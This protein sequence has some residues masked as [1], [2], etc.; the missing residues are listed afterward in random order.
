MGRTIA[1]RVLLRLQ[2]AE[3]EQSNHHLRDDY[4]IARI[5]VQLASNGNPIPHIE[6]TYAVLGVHP[7]KVW[8]KII[9]RR[10]ALLGK[11]YSAIY[12]AAG[13][14]WPQNSDELFPR[15]AS[16]S[17]SVFPPKKPVRSVTYAEEPQRLVVGGALEN[18]DRGSR[19]ARKETSSK[20]Q[21][22]GNLQFPAAVEHVD[23][24]LIMASTARIY[25]NPDASTSGKN[26][27]SFSRADIEKL[28]ENSDLPRHLYNTIV[29]MWRASQKPYGNEIYFFAAMEGYRREGRYK[30]K[31]TVRYNL[32]ALEKLGVIELVYHA[33]SRIRAD[34]FRHT[35][36]H[37]LNIQRLGQR[38]TYQQFKENQPIAT[39]LP[40]RSIAPESSTPAPS[41]APVT[42]IAPP[43][44]SS[45][46][47]RD[48]R[49]TERESRK[50]PD[51]TVRQRKELVQR[52]PIFMKGCHGNVATRYGESRY[53]GPDDPEYRAPMD[54]D[55]AILAACEWMCTNHGTSM[56]KALEAAADAGFRL[57]A[58]GDT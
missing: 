28:F 49:G 39:P 18:R 10:K 46:M 52:I 40:P 20:E 29:G 1:H 21:T 5:T 56:E 41:P 47:Q 6:A 12:D 25:R 53:I 54:K 19:A 43:S 23:K 30:S 11:L 33:N 38:E 14:L 48:H 42:P 13:N 51:L 27:R 45:T 58:K 37:R 32:R 34:R 22:A 15:H 17:S 2:S 57:V 9:A 31:R 26:P 24:P 55:S 7:D 35:A 44:R 3:S 4:H 50:L 16:A 8:G 36:T